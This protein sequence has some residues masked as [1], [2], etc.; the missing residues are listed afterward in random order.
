MEPLSKIENKAARKDAKTCSVDISKEAIQLTEQNF[1]LNH[2][3]T[4]EHRFVKANVFEFL[5]NIQETFDFIVLNPPA[6][7][8]KR[9]HLS[10]GS[11]AY[12][13][14][15]RLAIQQIKPNGLILTCSC[16]SHIDWSLFQK[17]IY[18]A[19]K[20]AKRKVQIIG[21]YGQPFDHPISIFH[22][23]SEYLKSLLLHVL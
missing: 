15:N 1:R 17:I 23:E 3:D 7:V 5:R 19:A 16:S 10:R 14:I 6:F 2:L 22:P 11:R 21:R 20:D 13:E 4:S 18:D 8:K 12:K 9:N